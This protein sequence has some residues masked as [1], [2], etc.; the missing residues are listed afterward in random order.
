MA[1][2]C[3]RRGVSLDATI[4]ETGSGL[5]GSRVL[6][7]ELLAGPDVTGFV[8][9]HRDRLARF[10]AGHLQAAVPAAASWCPAPAG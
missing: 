7:R 1:G 5:G 4:T 3:G 10:W 9:G 6:L 8:A 2:E